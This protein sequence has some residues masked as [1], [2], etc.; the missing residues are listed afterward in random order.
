M[1][2]DPTG[3][4]LA[5]ALTNG[6]QVYHFNG[7]QP[8][9]PFS[10]VKKT[11]NIIDQLGWDNA[12]HLYAQEEVSGAIHVYAVTSAKVEE[13]SGSPTTVPLGSFTI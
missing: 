1:K 9:T 7:P 13:T 3:A 10:N 6:V 8:I 11:A 5:V 4:F 12:G 2:I